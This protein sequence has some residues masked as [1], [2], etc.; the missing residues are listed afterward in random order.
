MADGKPGRRRGPEPSLRSQWLG[1]YLRD[2]RNEND[3]TLDEAAA[4][5]QKDSSMLSRYEKAEYPIRRGDVVALMSLYG[6]SDEDLR[7]G[8]M[9]L[10]E[11]IWKKGW[12]DPY[13][14]DVDKTFIDHPWLESRATEIRTYAP[15]IVPG[16]LQT[17]AYADV[18][19]RNADRS[20][21]D[22]KQF[23]RWVDLRMKRQQVLERENPLKFSVV[24]EEWALRRV[25][26]SRE[27]SRDQLQHLLGRLELP[28]IEV[29]V[30]PSDHGAHAGHL[31]SFELFEMFVP[32]P[33]VA[34]VETLAGTIYVER[35]NVERFTQAYDD[36]HKDALSP[37]KSA[38]L[39]SA[40]AEE[41]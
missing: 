36:L 25:I 9:Q 34:Y 14:A 31:G 24:I 37:E 8:L 12:W 4:F 29:R 28:T 11:D 15:M 2:L 30:M 17:P 5:L 20:D 21:A 22:E 38:E 27:I 13:A 35:P 26:G 41:T 7:N 23:A 18:L 10:A 33:E 1:Q 3:M 40:I 16:L 39:I 6:V 19:V 32:Y